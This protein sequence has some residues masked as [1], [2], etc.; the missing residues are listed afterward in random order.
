MAKMIFDLSLDQS[1]KDTII[2][3]MY[4]TQ[5]YNG[6]EW[7]FTGD[8]WPQWQLNWGQLGGNDFNHRVIDENGQVIIENSEFNPL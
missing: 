5:Y 8:E 3:T 7:I 6:N 2:N 1:L 4:K